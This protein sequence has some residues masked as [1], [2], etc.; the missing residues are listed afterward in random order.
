MGGGD[1]FLAV[2]LRAFNRKPEIKAMVRC[3][4][5]N[6]KCRLGPKLFIRSSFNPV[7]YFIEKGIAIGIRGVGGVGVP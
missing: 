6:L 7:F 3:G 2:D 4:H 5:R 1:H